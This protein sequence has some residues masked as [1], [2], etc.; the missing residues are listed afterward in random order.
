MF[1][2]DLTFSTANQ[3]IKELSK[4][5]NNVEKTTHLVM[6]Q[7]EAMTKCMAEVLREDKMKALNNNHE[8]GVTPETHL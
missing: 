6:K 3:N 4:R 1:I 2:F 8:S 7:L 5:L